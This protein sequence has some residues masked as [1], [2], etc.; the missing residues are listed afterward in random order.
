ML[1][2]EEFE[3]FNRDF[4]EWLRKHDQTIEKRPL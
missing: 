3:K 1:T 4:E 2:K